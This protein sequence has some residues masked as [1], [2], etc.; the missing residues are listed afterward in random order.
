MVYSHL[1]FAVG[2]GSW[3]LNCVLLDGYLRD[4]WLGP[5]VLVF[6]LK[7]LFLRRILTTNYLLLAEGLC[8]SFIVQFLGKC[9][10]G[11]P[12]ECLLA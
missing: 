2:M 1:E 5:R 8:T 11:S 9:Q 12:V 6:I 3:F 10:F 4:E 7:F